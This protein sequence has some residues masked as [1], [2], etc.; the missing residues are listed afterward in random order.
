MYVYIENEITINCVGS[1]F[2]F[3]NFN[4]M[5]I[6]YIIKFGFLFVC[7]SRTI[8]GSRKGAHVQIEGEKHGNMDTG[9][10]MVCTQWRLLGLLWLYAAHVHVRL[11]C[12]SAFLDVRITVRV[13]LN[14]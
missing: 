1:V 12:G 4:A 5:A 14:V 7:L 9:L 6:I 11:R 8:F 13:A 2:Y 3:D 10:N